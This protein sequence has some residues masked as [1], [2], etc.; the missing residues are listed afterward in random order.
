MSIL[1]NQALQNFD[2]E[3]KKIFFYN[4]KESFSGEEVKKKVLFYEEILKKNII[5]NICLN[6]P[7]SV[8][9]ATIYI[10]S[11]NVCENVWIVNPSRISSLNINEFIEANS[12]DC[13]VNE[14]KNQEGI[15]LDF[16]NLTK[17]ANKTKKSVRRDILFTSGTSGAPKGVMISEE[18]YIYVAQK[19]VSELKQSKKDLELL[20]M[21]FFHSFG[22]VRLRSVLLSK[23]SCLIVDGLKDFPKIYEFSKKNKITGLSLVPSGLEII[24]MLLKNKISDF[25]KSINYIEIGSSFINDDLRTWL[26]KNFTKTNILHHYGMTEASRA[27]LRPRGAKDDFKI[28]NNWIGNPLEGVKFKLLTSKGDE[29]LGELLLK[30]KNLFENYVHSERKILKRGWFHTKDICQIKNGKLFLMG[31]TDN[32]VN[33]GG[34]KVQL[35]EI[36]KI[37]VSLK[38]VHDATAFRVQDKILGEKIAAIVKTEKHKSYKKIK[39]SINYEF[40]KFPPFYK[41]KIIFTLK[42]LIR[43]QNG[44][45]IRDEKLIM[46]NLL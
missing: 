43:T 9:W 18:S 40:R 29:N 44:K 11:D 12:I 38:M 17:E 5:K 10:A 30:G 25:S 16:Y 19:L 36:E 4:L 13:I 31:R 39:D 32:Q 24:K 35:E 27:F 41:P 14:N 2:A 15:E 42:P 45:K 23:S 34:E 26:K 3:P 6:I 21:P 8:D 28:P 1:Y 7:N 22:L 37:L 33:I 20:S 46:D